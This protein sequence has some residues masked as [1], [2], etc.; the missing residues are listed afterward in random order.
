MKKGAS[1]LPNVAS[2]A[3]ADSWKKFGD[4]LESYF[5]AANKCLYSFETGG[6]LALALSVA[7]SAH[8][9]ALIPSLEAGCGAIRSWAEWAWAWACPSESGS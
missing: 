8:S 4:A 6:N 1:W 7:A 3:K 2:K 5:Q 9:V